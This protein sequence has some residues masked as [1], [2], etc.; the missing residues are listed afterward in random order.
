MD[1]EIVCGVDDGSFTL[2]V[3]Q[4]RAYALTVVPDE[5]LSESWVVSDAPATV[6]PGG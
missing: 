5:F 6:E 2:R 1:K 4:Q 3:S